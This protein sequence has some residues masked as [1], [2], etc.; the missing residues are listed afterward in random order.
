MKIKNKMK[1]KQKLEVFLEQKFKKDSKLEEEASKSFERPP[2]ETDTKG[3][4]SNAEKEEEEP[5]EP[6]VDIATWLRD[7]GMEKYIEAFQREEIDMD[8]LP[9]LTEDHLLRN[10]G[11]Q[12]IGARLTIVAAIQGLANPK[13]GTWK[14]NHSYCC[15]KKLA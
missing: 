14:V 2:N 8:I 6:I 3:I 4:I 9:D 12:S 11:V 10:L 13:K 15:R 7:L 1:V 5:C